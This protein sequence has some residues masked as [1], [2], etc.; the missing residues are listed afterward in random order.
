MSQAGAGIGTGRITGW[1]TALPD[2]VVTN[3][4]LSKT[5]DTNDEWIHER[6]GIRQRHVG[7]STAELAVEAGAAAMKSA[8]VGPDDID[9]VILAT[10]TPDKQCPGTAPVVQDQLGLNCGAVDMQA[11]CSGFVYGLVA[12][13]GML[14]TGANRILVIGAEQL[15]RIVDWTDRTTAILFGDGAGAVVMERTDGPGALLGW[16][17]GSAGEH[18][19][20]LYADHDGGCLTMNGREVFRQ[21][22][23]VMVEAS[24]VAMEMAGVTIDDIKVV[25]PHQ[26]NTRIIEAACKRLGCELDRT[27]LVLQNTGNT[28]SASIP[29]ALAKALDDERIDPGDLVLLVGFGAGMT[30]AAAVIRWDP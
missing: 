7:N 30:S 16:S 24:N 1:G 4:D 13:N 29:L 27:S 6:T 19:G 8:G 11:A 5:M 22:V 14:T 23:K 9:L 15:S 18:E 28:S 21:A 26:A 3:D 25:V 20:L 12:A 10:T 17:L 2:K